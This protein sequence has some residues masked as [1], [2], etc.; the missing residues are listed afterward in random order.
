MLIAHGMWSCQACLFWA[1]IR[2][3]E[4]YFYSHTSI[5]SGHEFPFIKSVSFNTNVDYV[6]T[7][8][9]MLIDS[10]DDVTVAFT[11]PRRP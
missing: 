10:V 1:L 2:K 5:R 4:M 6:C 8:I 7:E 11:F 9:D 3:T